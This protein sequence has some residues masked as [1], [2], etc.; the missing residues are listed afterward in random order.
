MWQLAISYRGTNFSKEL[1][2]SIFRVEK[3]PS[4]WRHQVPL[5]RLPNYQ[6]TLHHILEDSKVNLRSYDLHTELVRTEGA[7]IA[8]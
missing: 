1:A 5:Q 8:E 2:I 7:L 6:T 4:R 3:R